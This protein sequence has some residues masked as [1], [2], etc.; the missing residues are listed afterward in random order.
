MVVV[1]VVGK[2]KSSE[3]VGGQC[4]DDERTRSRRNC[5]HCTCNQVLTKRARSKRIVEVLKSWSEEE[6]WRWTG[7]LIYFGF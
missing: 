3:L 2:S 4:S 6:P 7:K 1:E 5:Y